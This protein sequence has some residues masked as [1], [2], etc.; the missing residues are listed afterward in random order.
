MT[1]ETQLEVERQATSMARR[2]FSGD[3]KTIHNK[4]RHIINAAVTIYFR[5]GAS[6][7]NWKL[8]H[9]RWFLESTKHKSPGTRYRYYRYLRSILIH[10]NHWVDWSPHLRG[11]WTT[12]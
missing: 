4:S 10:Y 6:P 7:N 11:P 8:K 5:F 3:R 12:P 1:R 2:T 9:I